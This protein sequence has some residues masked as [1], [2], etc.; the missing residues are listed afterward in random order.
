MYAIRS[1]YETARGT[2]AETPAQAPPY[3]LTP[4]AFRIAADDPDDVSE[5]AEP[6]A[7]PGAVFTGLPDIHKSIFNQSSPQGDQAEQARSKRSRFMTLLQTATK[8][9][10]NFSW[11][12]LQP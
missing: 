6:A 12:S 4:A 5:F 2:A 1:Y 7:Q 3:A 9:C 8:S 11:E 10:R